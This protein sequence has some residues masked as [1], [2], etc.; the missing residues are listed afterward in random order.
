VHT[1]ESI[2]CRGGCSESRSGLLFPIRALKSPQM[3][4]VSWGWSVSSINSIWVV[5]SVSCICLLCSD[6]LGGM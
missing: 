6:V 1:W 5:A 2:D 3:N 4:A